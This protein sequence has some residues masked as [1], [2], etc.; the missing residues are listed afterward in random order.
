M[1]LLGGVVFLH[2]LFLLHEVIAG[3]YVLCVFCS[4]TMYCKFRAGVCHNVSR[5]RGK[6]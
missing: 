2:Q 4:A 1:F 3:A 5:R 6:V